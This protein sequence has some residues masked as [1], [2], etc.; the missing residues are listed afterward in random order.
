L[1]IGLCD[2]HEL[3]DADIQDA[4]TLGVAGG[5]P[6]FLQSTGKHVW[7][8]AIKFPIY[9]PERGMLAFTVPGIHEFV[10]RQDE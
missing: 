4:M 10:S 5:Y 6:Y 7:D 1:G 3:V 8:N 9:A 2:L